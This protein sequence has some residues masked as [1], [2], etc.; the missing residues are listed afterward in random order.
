MSPLPCAL[1]PLQGHEGQCWCLLLEALGHHRN[2][3]Q[4]APRM[5][6]L[7]LAS[8]FLFCDSFH[9]WYQ[10]GAQCELTL[11]SLWG[12][13][14]TD[15][16]TKQHVNWREDPSL[17]LGFW[18]SCLLLLSTQTTTFTS[19]GKRH[20]LFW[21]QIEMTMAQEQRFGVPQSPSSNTVAISWIFYSTRRKKVTNEHIYKILVEKSERWWQCSGGIW[22]FFLTC[23][24][25]EA[26][27]L[28]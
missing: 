25:L 16:P 8:A 23:G 18:G 12:S 28:W 6:V 3:P 2:L 14:W 4:E 10:Q 13:S 24:L 11:L 27:G 15:A 9:R 22:R 19:K 21:R 26:S 17:G 5:E 20:S 1:E 7:L